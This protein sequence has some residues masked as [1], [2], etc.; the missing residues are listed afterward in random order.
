MTSQDFERIRFVARRYPE[1]QGLRLLILM[2]TLV[3][4]FWAHPYI[5]LLRYAGPVEAFIGLVA[6]VLPLLVA[7]AS[8]EYFNEYYGDRF[9]RISAAAEHRAKDWG[10]PVLLLFTGISLE[11]SGPGT[12]APSFVLIAAA[13]IA[14]HITVRDWPFRAHYLPAAVA[15]GV[16]AWLPAAIPAMRADNLPDIAR[17]SISLALALF[18]VPAYFDHRLLVRTLPSN[19]DAAAASAAD[20][21]SE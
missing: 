10:P 11:A 1:L 18:V 19:P 3:A 21:V 2:P 20:V 7:M 13:L 4:V 8:R 9:G 6:S 12:G 16:A 14:L 17:I 5:R 15:C